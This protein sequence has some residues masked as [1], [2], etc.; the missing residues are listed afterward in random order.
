MQVARCHQGRDDALVTP[1]G[2]H[3]IAG[4]FGEDGLAL[5]DLWDRDP[6]VCRILAGYGRGEQPLP[7]LIRP[8]S[9]GYARD[10]FLDLY[11]ELQS[12]KAA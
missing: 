2:R 11:H 9:P 7:A 3:Y 4:L 10:R 12:G 8:W 5:V 1:D 6:R